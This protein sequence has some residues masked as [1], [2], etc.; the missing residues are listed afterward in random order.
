MPDKQLKIAGQQIESADISLNRD[1]FM[2][3]LI[4]ELAETLE[5]V[6]GLDEAAGFISVV[7]QKIGTQIN[8]QYRVALNVESLARE[9]V[10]RVLV[11]LKKRIDGDFELVEQ[12]EEKLIFANTRCP[13]GSKVLG[14]P[15]MCMMTSN[16][17]GSIAANNLGRAK[18]SLENTIASGD[19]GCR[20]VVYLKSTDEAQ[21]AEGREYFQGV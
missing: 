16:V 14:R 18:V 9:Q 3:T 20:V 17:F 12:T 13:F 8:E 4:K 6:V 7:G 11:D 15:S 2:R 5:D 1:R 21:L 19:K 10:A